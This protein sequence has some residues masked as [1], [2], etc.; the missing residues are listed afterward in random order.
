MKQFNRRVALSVL[1]TTASA[2]GLSSSAHA[3]QPETHGHSTNNG[4]EIPQSLKAEHDKLHED[5]VQATK[6]GGETGTAA[7]VVANL[8]HPH[9][10]KEEELAMPPLGLLTDLANGRVTQEMRKFVKLTDELKRQLPEM[11]KE[12]E[13]I[14]AALDSL[15]AASQKENQP[16]VRQFAAAL[17]QHVKT[18]EE[19]LYPASVLIG[20]YL[21]LKVR[22]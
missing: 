12:H 5:V 19:V 3:A 2:T 21:K 18:E 14:V 10:I 15:S 1:A 17:K 4:Y 20:E 16:H 7:R 22:T 13:A 9:F 11:L 6:A 8:L